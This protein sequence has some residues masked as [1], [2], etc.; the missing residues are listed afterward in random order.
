[1]LPKRYLQWP[2]SQYLISFPLVANPERIR[3]AVA[4]ETTHNPRTSAFMIYGCVSRNFSV[5]F[6]RMVALSIDLSLILSLIDGINEWCL[7]GWKH[8]LHKHR[9]LSGIIGGIN[10]RVIFLLVVVD[11]GIHR[12][13]GKGRVPLGNQIAGWLSEPACQLCNFRNDITFFL[14]W[15][16]SLSLC[17]TYYAFCLSTL[18]CVPH[19][20]AD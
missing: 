6:Q 3:F 16:L 7:D 13:P 12:Q 2:P 19:K 9:E 10:S 17:Y 14:K 18:I 20:K 1:M 15:S 5:C 11:D 8:K 4:A